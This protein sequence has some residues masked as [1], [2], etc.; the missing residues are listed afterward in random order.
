MRIINLRDAP[1]HVSTLARW[2]FEEWGYLNPGQS[3]EYR[4][5]R[6]ERY[7][8]DD[9]LPTMLIAVDGSEVVGSAALIESDM[10]THPELTPWLANVYVRTDQRGKGI[11]KQLVE[12][13]M[14]LASEQHLRQLYL[15][16][17]DQASFYA[18]LGWLHH[19]HAIYRGTD[20][21][22][23]KFTPPI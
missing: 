6:V 23:M 14:A 17:P 19:Q 18:R 4:L 12:A 1:E 22:I 21:T 2:F 15:F 7:L 13:I 10:D 9:L 3:F 16:T 11:G 5:A 8:T 20:V